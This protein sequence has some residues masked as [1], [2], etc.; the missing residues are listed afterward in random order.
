MSWFYRCDICG[1]EWARGDSFDVTIR[2]YHVEGLTPDEDDTTRADICSPQC[3]S[4]LAGRL[5]EQ[6]KL[7]EEDT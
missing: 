5:I 2:N 1:K 6:R 3:L 7:I 4:M